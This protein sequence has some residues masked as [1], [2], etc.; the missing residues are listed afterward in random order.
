M[1]LDADPVIA[2]VDLAGRA[3]A[4]DFQIGWDCPHVADEGDGHHCPDVTWWA[5][6]QWRGTRTM[7]DG[8]PTPA[9]AAIA[10]AVRI[11]HG[12]G[13]KCG[14]PVTITAGEPDQC[15]WRLIGQRWEPGCDAPP[16]DMAGVQRGDLPAMAHRLNRA[17]RRARK[18]GRR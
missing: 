14:R 16:I 10:L 12:G 17:Q 13:C 5:S 9:F 6:V 15:W 3:G 7:V 1:S 8:H 11:L 2:C 4:K 18:R